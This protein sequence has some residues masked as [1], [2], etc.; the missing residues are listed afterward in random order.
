MGYLIQV[1][2]FHNTLKKSIV[3]W[4]T[5]SG[6]HCRR[7]TATSEFVANMIWMYFSCACAQLYMGEFTSIDTRRIICTLFFTFPKHTEQFNRMRSFLLCYIAKCWKYCRKMRPKKKRFV[8]VYI[9][10]Y[11]M[12]NSA[13]YSSF[14]GILDIRAFSWNT[15]FIYFLYENML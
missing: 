10:Q 12:M 13:K 1:L 9:D 11:T 7:F 4:S 5:S 8:S 3:L 6:K 14:E 2:R 15:V